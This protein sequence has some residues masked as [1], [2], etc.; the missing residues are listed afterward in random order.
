MVDSISERLKL[1]IKGW[2]QR[3]KDE[4]K[5]E[6]LIVKMKRWSKD[7]RIKVQMKGWTLRMDNSKERRIKG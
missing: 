7:E 3:W 1:Q 4:S 6:K 5:D 2:K